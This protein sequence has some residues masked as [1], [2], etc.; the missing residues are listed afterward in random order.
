MAKFIRTVRFVFLLPDLLPG[1]PIVQ[2]C[3]GEEHNFCR[4]GNL[5]VWGQT[6]QASLR[7]LLVKSFYHTGRS[8]A[9]CSF[10]ILFLCISLLANRFGM[11]CSPLVITILLLAIH[12]RGAL[13]SLPLFHLPEG[14]QCLQESRWPWLSFRERETRKRYQS[15][16]EAWIGWS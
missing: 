15:N 2:N 13:N 8:L 1:H 3:C 10:Q 4:V 16:P 9:G 12:I 7:G 14:H 11:D 6:N 5:E